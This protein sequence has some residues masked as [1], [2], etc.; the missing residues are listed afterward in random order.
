MLVSRESVTYSEVPVRPLRDVAREALVDIDQALKAL[1]SF[2]V[3]IPVGSRLHQ[4][5]DI[6]SEAINTGSLIP[7]HRGD[8]LGLRALEVA[9]DFAAIAD[10]LP[11]S[12]GPVASMRRELATALTGP[13]DPPDEGK[14]PLQL[15]SQ[16]IV[17]SAF[18]EGGGD[19]YHP[20]HS[21]GAGRKSPDILL[22][23]GNSEYAIEVKRPMH[24]RSILSRLD[25]ARAQ[26]EGFGLSGGVVVDITDCVRDTDPAAL[27]AEVRHIALS[28]YERIFVTGQGYRS[29]YERI[30]MAGVIARRAW[31]TD[32]NEDSAMI[33]VHT[34]STIGIF[35]S[36]RG[37]LSDHRAKWLRNSLEQGL[38]RLYR[39]LGERSP[40]E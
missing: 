10:S 25:D 35:A 19:P 38:E 40:G 26:L 6:L 37:T 16:L 17:R 31:T 4:A 5:R 8:H 7:S 11:P 27:E 14:G 13:I 30:M 36:A 28:L 2:G 18:R 39:T 1:Q 32:E 21:A 29:G 24:R 23:N 9:F 22:A 12:D 3:R 34:L 33:E 20:T 15:Q